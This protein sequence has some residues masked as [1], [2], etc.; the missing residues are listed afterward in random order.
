MIDPVVAWD[1]LK[2]FETAQEIREYFQSEGVKAVK[3]DHKSCAIAQWLIDTTGNPS[4]SVSS[5][6]QIGIST[7]TRTLGDDI[8]FVRNQA[9]HDFRHTPATLDFIEEFDNGGYPELESDVQYNAEEG[10]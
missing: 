5:S 4:V 9:D 7:V 6:V 3:G 2:N 8:Q 1:K 10:F